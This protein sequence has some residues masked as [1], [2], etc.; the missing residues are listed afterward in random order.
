MPVNL[1]SAG[2]K[3]D[4]GGG[5][6]EILAAWRVVYKR[7]WLVLMTALG[8]FSVVYGRTLRLPRIYQAQATVIID[9]SAPRLLPQANEVMALGTGLSSN[10]ASQDYYNTQQR[11]LQSWSLA[12]RIVHEHKFQDD[13]R[14]TGPIAGSTPDVRVR[15]AIVAVQTAIRVLPVKDSRVFGIAVRHEDKKFAAELANAVAATYT[16][17]NIERKLEVTGVARKW[18]AKQ[19]DDASERLA[20]AETALNQFRLRNNILTV[21]LEDSQNEL[22]TQLRDFTRAQM[23]TRRNRIDLEARRQALSGLASSDSLEAP[24]PKSATP[25]ALENLRNIYMEERRKLA[26][27]EE[28]YGER[29]H[30]VVYARTRAAAAKADLDREASNVIK[31]LD[32]E[33]RALATAEAT[34]E[35]EAKGFKADALNLNKKEVDYKTLVREAADAEQQYNSLQKRLNDSSL[36]ERDEANNIRLLDRALE[37]SSPVEPNLTNAMV[38]AIALALF[39]GLGLAYALHLL[40]RTI[41]TQEDVE[42]ATG[43]PVLGFL[44]SFGE[45]EPTTGDVRSLYILKHPASTAAE[46]CRVIRTNVVFSSPDKPFRSLVV[47]SS[48]PVEG[49]TT[50]V[51]N[52]GIV[53]AQAGHRTLVVDSDM[54]RPRLHKLLR[55][56]NERG[57][58]SLIVGECSPE[59]AVKSTD[60]PNLSVLPCG[61]LPPNPAELLQSEKFAAVKEDLLSRFD[62]IIFDSPPLLAVT[63]GA[64]LSREV[65]GTILVARAGKTTKEALVRARRQLVAVGC[66][67]AGVVVNDVN[68]KNSSYSE[69]YYYYHHYQQDPPAAT[70]G[71]STG[72]KG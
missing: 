42:N 18:L 53:M 22:T 40:D 38:M 59:D 47:T 2:L 72:E 11:I 17:Q 24:L 3:S 12:E 55:V 6:A 67:V 71:A 70:A 8:V 68:L 54:R 52:L 34:F 32:A 36:Q 31:G 1:P 66:H 45:P 25:L 4:D 46:A 35:R 9:P 23:E 39:A 19:A 26:L 15:R 43:F 5:R 21:A 29:H 44:P 37:P 61:P 56:S 63:D 10:Y 16:A 51:V 20:K 49:K 33:I 14:V 65:D 7:K 41:K 64:L 50:N 13:P 57:L 27:A 28:R 69:Y 30:E 62:R 58:S 60:L 48:S